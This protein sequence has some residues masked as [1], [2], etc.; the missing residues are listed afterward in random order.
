VAEYRLNRSSMAKEPTEGSLLQIGFA[1][2]IVA[3]STFGSAAAST[4]IR[5][6][7]CRKPTTVHTPRS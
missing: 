2:P 6:D 4:A 1:E 7:F 3:R 5:R